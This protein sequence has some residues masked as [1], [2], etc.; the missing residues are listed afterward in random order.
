MVLFSFLFRRGVNRDGELHRCGKQLAERILGQEGRDEHRGQGDQGKDEAEPE[1]YAGVHEIVTGDIE[2]RSQCCKNNEHAEI[3][4]CAGKQ[5]ASL[6]TE[7]RQDDRFEAYKK[8]AEDAGNECH[9]T[10]RAYAS[11]EYILS[12]ITSGP[13]PEEREDEEQLDCTWGIDRWY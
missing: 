6:L 1:A 4:R 10:A 13:P 8:D 12:I 11:A 3:P 2:Q 5:F 9:P 7:K